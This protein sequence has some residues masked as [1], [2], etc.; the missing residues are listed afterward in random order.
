M[1][2]IG[3]DPSLIST[4]V[5]INGDIINYCRESSVLTKSGMSKWFKSVE[6]YCQYKFIEYSKF[7]NYSEGELTKLKDYDEITDLIIGDIIS[8]IDI[9]KETYI[10]I[11]G[12]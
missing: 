1:N 11:E 3:I 8:K 10:G 7:E 12:R 9:S 5:V 4:A 2:Y 6:Q